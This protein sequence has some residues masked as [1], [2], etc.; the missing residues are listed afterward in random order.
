MTYTDTDL[1]CQT[2]ICHF[3]IIINNN[4]YCTDT[5]L[6]CTYCYVDRWCLCHSAYVWHS[7][8][9]LNPETQLYI[10]LLSFV[11]WIVHYYSFW[12]VNEQ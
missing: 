4:Y 7:T 8:E 3:W 9:G 1:L 10:I 11:V 5:D 6:L 2:D 12:L